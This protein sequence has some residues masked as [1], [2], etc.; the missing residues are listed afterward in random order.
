MDQSS[1]HRIKYD[2]A[3]IE[4]IVYNGRATGG[5]PFKRSIPETWANCDKPGILKRYPVWVVHT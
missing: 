2:I 3:L 4:A 5:W 1:D